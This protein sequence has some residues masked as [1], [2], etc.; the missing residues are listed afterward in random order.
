MNGDWYEEEWE[1]EEFNEAEWG[2]IPS[3]NT[4]YSSPAVCQ[5]LEIEM[6]HETPLPSKSS[7]ASCEDKCIYE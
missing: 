2:L 4:F 7:K 3:T 5:A 6:G 1:T